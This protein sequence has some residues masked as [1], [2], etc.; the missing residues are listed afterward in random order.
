MKLEALA[1]AAGGQ[2][3][4]YRGGNRLGEVLH[5]LPVPMQQLQRRLKA[6]LDPQGIFN[7][8]RLYGWL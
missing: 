1:D 5:S 8:G 7:P 3:S 6:A 2:V 4:L